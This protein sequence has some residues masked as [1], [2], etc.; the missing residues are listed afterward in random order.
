MVGT[1]GSGCSSS[2]E[3]L[4][5][6]AASNPLAACPESPNC[7]RIS[8]DVAL[9]ADS[10]FA[11]TRQALRALGP[12]RLRVR[13]E[14]RRATAVYRVAWLFRDDVAVA[15]EP[16]SAGS[17]LHVRSASRTGY[18]DLGV[19]RRRVQRLLEHLPSGGTTQD[20]RR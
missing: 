15:V 14:A 17:R 2:S 10:L 7:E 18:S 12:A 6:A 19:N 4:P 20:A 5:S 1:V 11:R 3:S 13:P 8:T 16:R 9:P